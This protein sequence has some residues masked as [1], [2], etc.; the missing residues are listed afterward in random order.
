MKN[1]FVAIV[2]FF[3]FNTAFAGDTIENLAN[4][5]SSME[6]A[7]SV[8]ITRINKRVQPSAEEAAKEVRSRVEYT[9][10]VLVDAGADIAQFVWAE[11][12]NAQAE[13][14]ERIDLL[15][16]RLNNHIYRDR[17]EHEKLQAQI[18][19]LKAELK[20]LQQASKK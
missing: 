20:K 8:T 16:K 6:D 19:V 17:K 5:L 3:S 4:F 11:I 7:G 15:E 2:A 10:T 18:N 14:T 13:I 12:K 1:L 9:S